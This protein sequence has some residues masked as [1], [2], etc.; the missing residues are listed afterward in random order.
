[1]AFQFRQHPT[2]TGDAARVAYYLPE[3]PAGVSY[4]LYQHIKGYTEAIG[5]GPD[6][7][8]DAAF[9]HIRGYKA[10]CLP[11]VIAKV[12]YQLHFNH[13][14]LSADGLLVIL[15]STDEDT[16]AIELAASILDELYGQLPDGW[17]A[18]RQAYHAAVIVEHEFDRRV[19]QPAYAAAGSHDVPA[20]IS[21]E[22]ERL[23]EA[24]SVAEQCLLR[25]PA[26]SISEWAIKFLICFDCERDMNGYTADLCDEARQLL[27]IAGTPGDDLSGELPLLEATASWTTPAAQPPFLSPGGLETPEVTEPMQQKAA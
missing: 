26:P 1:M 24:R 3:L 14:G 2:A 4:Q 5:Q 17:E 16:A 18:A 27:G 19:Y 9:S 6:E 22:Q 11:D 20:V 8:E 25:T 21:D 15:E 23:L 7:A 13:R 10:R 12:V